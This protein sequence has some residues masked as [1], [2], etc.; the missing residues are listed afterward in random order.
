MSRA[1]M[2][3]SRVLARTETAISSLTRKLASEDQGQ[4]RWTPLDLSEVAELEQ[5][6]ET[7][8]RVAG[9]DP[10]TRILVSPLPIP[11][12]SN[13]HEFDLLP[14]PDIGTESTSVSD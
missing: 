1:E 4:S 10:L 12:N 7:V 2:V 5:A 13:D 11:A 3:E 8:A 6:I 9:V 14:I